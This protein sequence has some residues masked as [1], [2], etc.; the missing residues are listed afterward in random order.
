MPLQNSTAG[1]TNENTEQENEVTSG[2]RLKIAENGTL[3]SIL[4]KAV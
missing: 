3:T 2:T 4:N 1:Q